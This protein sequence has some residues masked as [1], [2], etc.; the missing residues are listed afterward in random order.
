MTSI[1]LQQGKYRLFLTHTQKMKW[2]DFINWFALRVISLSL[3]MMKK[4]FNVTFINY[5]NKIFPICHYTVL[6]RRIQGRGLGAH[7]SLFLDQTEARW[8]EKNILEDVP[9]PPPLHFYSRVWM[10]SPLPLSGS[11]MVITSPFIESKVKMPPEL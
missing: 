8:A 1:S 9:P 10:T 6:Q 11:A 2:N 3:K 4:I 7:P 5:V